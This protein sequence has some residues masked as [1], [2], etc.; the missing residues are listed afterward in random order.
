M[1]HYGLCNVVTWKCESLLMILMSAVSKL[2]DW[3][4]ALPALGTSWQIH[5][6]DVW[7]PDKK[8][9]VVQK[10]IQWHLDRQVQYPLK[11]FAHNFDKW[12]CYDATHQ[13][14]VFLF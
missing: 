3:I 12:I 8:E 13:A 9:K 6:I 5:E 10:P 2:S 1:K 14:Y 11:T 7:I 4:P